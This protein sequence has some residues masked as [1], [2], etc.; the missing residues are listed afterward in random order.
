MDR[1]WSKVDKSGDC[2][3][4][5]AYRDK[6]GYGNISIDNKTIRAHRVSWELEN[7][8]INGELQCLHKCDN[9]PCVN[10]A[11]L[12][13]GTNQDNVTDKVNKGRNPQGSQS[14]LS[15]LTDADV[16]EI[17][18]HGDYFT[19]QEIANYY[20]IQKAA[21]QKILYYKRWNHI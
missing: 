21:V 8:K 17:R 19:R 10:P 4:W 13:L 9:P 3:E 14:K 20:G 7:G 12:F 16:D 6:D 15:K 2:W 18:E 5:K 11:H 1:F